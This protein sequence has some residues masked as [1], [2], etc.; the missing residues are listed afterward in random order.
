MRCLWCYHYFA[1]SGAL[2]GTSADPP[3]FWGMQS[4][5]LG[6][7][8]MAIL[9]RDP[10]RFGEVAAKLRGRQLPGVLRTYIWM[11]VLLKRERDKLNDR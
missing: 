7:S 3:V 10:R 1:V 5:T 2:F 4:N 11:D 8:V 6:R 9:K